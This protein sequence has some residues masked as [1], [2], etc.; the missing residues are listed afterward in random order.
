MIV[1]KILIDKLIGCILE[2]LLP[3]CTTVPGKDYMQQLPGE[4]MSNGLASQQAY[5]AATGKSKYNR[6]S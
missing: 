1:I 5:A 6:K 4:E 3:Q 2:G